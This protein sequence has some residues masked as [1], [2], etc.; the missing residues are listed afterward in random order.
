LIFK[1]HSFLI[2]YT[3]A[4]VFLPLFLPAFPHTASPSDPL[5]CFPLQ[6]SRPPKDNS[7][8][9]KT[10]YSKDKAKIPHIEVKQSNPIG[11]KEA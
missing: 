8:T 4:T 10:G 6:K 7:H 9:D 11:A 3:L 1:I 5:L 2:Q